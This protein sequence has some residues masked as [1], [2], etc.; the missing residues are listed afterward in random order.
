MKKKGITRPI[1]YEWMFGITPVTPIA[2]FIILV[3]WLLF[4][5]DLTFTEIC[6]FLM[7][8]LYFHSLVCSH[9]LV[10]LMALRQ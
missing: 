1:K 2:S 7:V 9:I 6:D 8:L 3:R 10:Y 4:F 5:Y